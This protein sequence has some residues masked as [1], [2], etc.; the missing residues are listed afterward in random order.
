MAVSL[1]ARRLLVEE[2]PAVPLLEVRS[3][4][5]AVAVQVASEN[6]L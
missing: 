6:K 3:A 4:H 2:L 5:L 1:A